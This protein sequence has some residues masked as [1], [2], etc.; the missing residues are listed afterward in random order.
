MLIQR[1][2]FLLFFFSV[3]VVES[4]KNTGFCSEFGMCLTCL[5]VKLYFHSSHFL[6]V[7]RIMQIIVTNI[8]VTCCVYFLTLELDQKEF[9]Y[10]NRITWHFLRSTDSFH[11]R[12]WTRCISVL[13]FSLWGSCMLSDTIKMPFKI[14]CCQVATTE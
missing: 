11:P 13:C 4:R 9:N 5:P 12:V 10:S 8:I 7:Y 3:L 6:F 14:L 1:F 2:S